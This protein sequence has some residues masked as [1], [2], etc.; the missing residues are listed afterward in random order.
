MQTAAPK[1]I[2]FTFE[3]SDK[4]KEWMK[5]DEVMVKPVPLEHL[6][7]KIEQYL[8]KKSELR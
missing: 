6:A 8:A 1:K 3:G 4:E 5:V 2:G 7:G